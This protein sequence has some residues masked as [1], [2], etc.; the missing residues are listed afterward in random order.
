VVG[1]LEVLE[2]L[3]KVTRSLQGGEWLF[4]VQAAQPHSSSVE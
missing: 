1:N 2:D 3:G 4:A